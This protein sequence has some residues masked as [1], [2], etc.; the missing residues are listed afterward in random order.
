[1]GA[2]VAAGYVPHVQEQLNSRFAIG[3]ALSEMIGFQEEF[4]LFSP[5][6]TLKS[7]FALLN[8]APVGETDREGFF[9]Y[10]K[11]LMKTKAEVDEVTSTLSGHDQIL[12][13]LRE[14]LESK[15]PLPVY[16]TWHI[17][18]TPKGIVRITSGEPYS[19]SGETY[20]TI[21]VPTIREDRP[22][23]GKRKKK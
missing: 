7:A 14:N 6:H 16:F 23:A 11:S 21:S 22:K 8:I 17:G 1:M 13:S 3:D 12:A 9:K 15:R 20:L 10:L 5:P 19:F 2:F 18:E 4:K